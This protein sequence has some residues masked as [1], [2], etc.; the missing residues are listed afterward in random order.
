MLFCTTKS[1]SLLAGAL[2]PMCAAFLSGQTPVGL[3]GGVARDSAS[4]KPVAKALIVA[5]HVSGGVDST[6]L[7]NTDGIFTFTHLEPGTYEVAASKDGFQKSSV[8]VEVAPMRSARV[9]LALQSM[10]SAAAAP[11]TEREKMLLDRIEKLESRLA[12]VESKGTPAPD[13]AMVASLSPV[14]AP[15]GPV[16]AR[17]PLSALDGEGAATT[18]PRGRSAKTNDSRSAA[19]ARS[20]AGRRQ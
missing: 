2:L 11:L 3:I 4:G 6:E 7:T 15:V 17:T 8:R 1:R 16:P 5:H 20:R 13:K 12:A 10:N 9:E 14:T 18:G 19:I